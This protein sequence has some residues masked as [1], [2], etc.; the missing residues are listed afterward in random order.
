MKTR[1]LVLLSFLLS[2]SLFAQTY[3]DVA[4]GYGTLNDAIKNNQ[5]NVIY[6]LQAG[7]WYTLS[8]QI[9]NNGFTLQ[10]VGTT[11]SQGEM[12]AAI[13][14]AT[15]N[16]G[17]VIGDMFNIVG[18]LIIKDVFIV[19]ANTQ[20]TMGQGVFSVSSPTSVRIVFD[21]LTVDPVGSNHFIVFNPT[22]Y[23]KLFM[24]NSLLLR[25]GTLAGA[26]DWCLFD[27]AGPVNNGYDTLYLENNTFVST[28]THIAINRSGA[29]DSNNVVWINHN[30]FAFH[31]FQLF[32]GFHMNKYYVT[33]NLF[34]D[35]T[36]MPYNLAWDAYTPDQF[37]DKYQ[38]NVE[39][40]TVSSDTVNGKVMSSRKL[41]VEYNSEYVDPRIQAYLSTW[42]WTH[43]LN[44]T[45]SVPVGDL[46]TA[47]LMRL[48]YPP[49]SAGVNREANMY[50]SSS[51]PYF[52]FGNYLD[53][54]DPEWTNQ[55]MYAIQ[56]SMVE[57]TLPAM[58]LNNWGFNPTLVP[59]PANSG[60]WWWCDD[61]VYNLGN[62]VAWPR[63]NGSYSNTTTLTASIAGLP[64]GDLNWFPN[65]KALWE[66]NQ[67][68]ITQHI[69]NED[70][71]RFAITGIKNENVQLPSKFTL[72]QNYP[73][74]FNPSTEIRYSISQMSRVTL[75]V[76]NSLGQ[77]IA[78]LVDRQEQ[79]GNYNVEFNASQLA[80]GVYFY[81]L[82][83]NNSVSTKK[84]ILLK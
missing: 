51:F 58:E 7:G 27:L 22:P 20:N 17:T 4:P 71:T 72:S 46:N 61:S 63:F 2:Y 14:T 6:R 54:V 57:W 45:G 64:L 60:N 41:F 29:T 5:G 82:E 43:T 8:G 24:T 50:G 32:D 59:A 11:P 79:P 52:K 18:N 31:K 9:E 33:N 68:T 30:T 49:D 74:P 10:I 73:N 78:T 16:D 38:A 56:D 37:A 21:S 66:Q 48:A 15:N 3:L 12:P 25:H 28:G 44:D 42:Q 36:T 75:K 53:D 67:A 70:T 65:K 1:L 39:Q 76:Y 34:F 35:F 81:Q 47:Y 62:P 55:K 19:N 23:P 83:S 84:M 13:Q 80:S 69:I 26:N 77:Q 40:D